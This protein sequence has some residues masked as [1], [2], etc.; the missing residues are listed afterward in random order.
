MLQGRIWTVFGWNL[1]AGS[2]IN[3]RS[4]LNFPMQ[5]NGAEML[6]LACCLATEQ[7]V[8]VCAPIHD[9]ILVEAP[10]E[11]LSD[12]TEK[13]QACMAEAS[14]VVLDDFELR[15]GATLICHPDRFEDERGLEMWSKV[16]GILEKQ[17]CTEFGQVTCPATA[18]VPVSLRSTRPVLS[19]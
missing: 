1:H 19:I 4:L 2:S 8:C 9:A 6:R 13:A 15:S 16:Q 18:H 17:T 14:R 10:L 5:A 3:P 7:G 12:A 11:T